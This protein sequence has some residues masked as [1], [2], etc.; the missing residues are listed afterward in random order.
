[1]ARASTPSFKVLALAVAVFAGGAQAAESTVGGH[2]RAGG[3]LAG[4]GSLTF[5]L[6][7]SLMGAGGGL[8]TMGV[9]RRFDMTSMESRELMLVGTLVG[10]G[11][12]FGTSAYWQFTHWIGLPMAHLGISNSLASGMF[13]AGL[14]D[15]VSNDPALITWT[16]FIGAELGAWLTAVIAGGELSLDR[17]IYVGSGTGWGL[18]YGLL[19]WA[20]VQTSGGGLSAG[21]S[22]DMLLVSP[23]IGLIASSLLALKFNPSAAQ[24]ARADLFG[25]AVGGGVL[26]LSAIVLGFRF[27]IATPYILAALGSAGAMASV[28]FLW[29]DSAR[30]S[31]LFLRDPERDRPYRWVWW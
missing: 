26:L 13:F 18:V 5:I 3:F 30:S 27:D 12:G 25:A 6:H 4:P 2:P 22:A 31:N 11:A 21:D 9:P 14:V 28:A 7:H 1:M 15:L 29:A 10:A 19:L 17:A 23:G 8:S 24:V 20:I 16:S